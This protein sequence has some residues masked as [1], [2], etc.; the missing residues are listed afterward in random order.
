MVILIDWRRKQQ[1]CT[2]SAASKIDA[3][4]TS[5][6]K[7]AIRLQ[8]TEAIFNSNIARLQ[9]ELKRANEQF[10]IQRLD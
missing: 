7:H 1:P 8:R 3:I 10:D 9:N 6:Y 5:H 2:R 4:D